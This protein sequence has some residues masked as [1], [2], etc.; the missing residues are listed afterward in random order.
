MVALTSPLSAEELSAGIFTANKIRARMA[1]L[2][3]EQNSSW[4]TDEEKLTDAELIARAEKYANLAAE[5]D[6]L[7][8]WVEEAELVEVSKFAS[9]DTL[10]EGLRQ[11]CVSYLAEKCKR[12][13]RPKIRAWLEAG[14]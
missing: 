11:E 6:L 9:Y 4:Q 2:K 13:L 8:A 7:W 12:E 5:A 10:A 1:E 3:G 14:A